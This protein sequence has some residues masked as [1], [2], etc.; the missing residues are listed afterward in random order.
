MSVIL[1]QYS[2]YINRSKSRLFISIIQCL[3]ICSPFYI[4]HLWSEPRKRVEA[5]KFDGI[6]VKDIEIYSRNI[7]CFAEDC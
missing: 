2:R 7:Y 4:N 1:Q 3:R 6:K 5:K